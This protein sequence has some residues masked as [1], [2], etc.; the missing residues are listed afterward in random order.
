[1]PGRAGPRQARARRAPRA[2]AGVPAAPAD[3]PLALALQGGGSHGAFT[4]GVL[5]RL[6]DDA[7][8]PISGISGTSAGALNAAVLAC[9]WADGGR[10]GAQAALRAFWLDV[11]SKQSPWHGGCFG[12]GVGA[13]PGLAAYNRDHHPFHA[14]QRQ[15]LR[16]WSPCQFNPLGADP[17][18]DVL[19][20][21][22]DRAGQRDAGH[23]LRQPAVGRW[24]ADCGRLQGPAAAHGGRRRRP[25]RP[26]A[27]VRQ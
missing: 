26:G 23:R 10:A 11:A 21:H 20:R 1:M 17:L 2:A 8:L 13:S 4:W 14:W 5:D 19:A 16:L 7:S 27:A 15:F 12:G 6:L 18:R 25:G 3:T 24:P 9:G 22:V